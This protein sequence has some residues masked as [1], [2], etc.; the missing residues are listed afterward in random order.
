MKIYNN[1]K[2]FLQSEKPAKNKHK[3]KL[4]L[5]I[6]F[7]CA[8]YLLFDKFSSSKEITLESSISPNDA[9]I[10]N[11]SPAEKQ[12][13]API[14]HTISEGDIPAEV[15]SEHGKL[16]AND[17][18]ALLTASKDTYDFTN[19][20]IGKNIRFYFDNKNNCA[21]R[22]EYDRNTETMIVAQKNGDSFE[23]HEEEIKYE[24]S[25][26]TS[27]VNIDNFLYI[28][29]LNAGISESTILEI[30]DIFSFDIDFTTEI[31]QGD[32]F[33]IVYEKR[34]RDGREASDGKVLAAK[35]TNA[36]NDYYGYYFNG[37]ED[38]GHYDSE[39]H[40][41]VRQFLRAPLSYRQIT[42]GYTGA[43]VHPIT[44][45]V[46][47]HYQIDYA[48]PT[49][50][51]VVATARGDVVSAGWESGWGNI[52]RLRHANGYTTHYG[53][54]SAFGKGIKSGAQVSQGQIIGY[55][56]ST[57][58]STGPHLDYGMRL[59]GNPINPMALNLPKG[60]ILNADKMPEFEKIKEKYNS[61]L[62]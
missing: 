32:S 55:V 46:S 54:L 27:R 24:I 50:T 9:V 4:L 58:W 12:E 36:G 26:K 61:L 23:V 22:I 25:Q 10:E 35:F 31:R 21:T 8:I 13:K 34:I 28:D 38:D 40:F 16:D 37:G 14:I 39:G 18:I 62:K 45:T 33:I 51:P 52:V 2:V 49:G 60:N 57:G 30:A 1:K 5:G 47:A 53:H 56:G 17:I 41:L 11:A 48:A 43:R 3:F 15:F 29:A 19:I 20:K 44:K 6:F 59:N 7:I 42:S